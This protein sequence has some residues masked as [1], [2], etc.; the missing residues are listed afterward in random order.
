[1]VEEILDCTPK[2]AYEYMAKVAGVE[3]DNLSGHR[4]R[5][6]GL[7]TATLN[8]EDEKVLH[9]H[10]FNESGEYILTE[11]YK[12]SR[13]EYYSLIISRAEEMKT[14][15]L[16]CKAYSSPN[17][18]KAYDVFEMLGDNFDVSIYG[19]IDHVIDDRV[20]LCERII[21][22]FKKAEEYDIRGIVK[23]N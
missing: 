3:L 23:H 21:T 22:T 6:S 11:L 13:P 7:P 17:A 18:P 15:Y 14:R 9:M 1:M 12:K 4:S 20:G 19:K 10:C 8:R 5:V 2:E 16:E